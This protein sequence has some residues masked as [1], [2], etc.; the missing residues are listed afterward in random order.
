MSKKLRSYEIYRIIN[1][2]D[3]V[4]KLYQRLGSSNFFRPIMY[5]IRELD[6][7][8]YRNQRMKFYSQFMKKGN[9]VFDIGS[10]IGNRTDIFLGLGCFVVSVE[11]QKE[12]VDYLR[13]KF[14]SNKNV[15]F[16]DKAVD[17]KIQEKQ[18]Y[19][20]GSDASSSMSAEW[21][22]TLKKGKLRNLE[23]QQSV[24]VST[25]TLDEL[26]KE[27]GVPVFCKIDVEGYE[28]NVLKGLSQPIPCISFEFTA[29][30]IVDAKKCIQH[31]SQ[32]G[33]ATFNCSFGESM[34]L[35][36]KEWLTAKEMIE[37]LSN[38]PEHS[39]GDV[40]ARFSEK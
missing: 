38:M 27:Y 5:H 31:L 23:W 14:H 35:E 39:Q 4:G 28:L 16:V 11:P 37:S 25:T 3:W 6:N 20:C 34:E 18:L 30:L 8:R 2:F 26:V 15:V 21:I 1:R 29:E 32:L 17:E 7:K 33:T 36:F 13:K 40:Y 24:T 9:T 22:S 10:N 12:C 19:I